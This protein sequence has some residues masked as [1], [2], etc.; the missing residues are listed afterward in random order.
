[1]HSFTLWMSSP[2][3]PSMYM[4]SP[5]ADERGTVKMFALAE[6][7]A[8]ED[9][10]ENKCSRTNVPV[11][12]CD[13]TPVLPRLAAIPTPVDLFRVVEGRRAEEVMRN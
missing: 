13:V 9:N 2:A 10:D 6:G 3:V 11:D 8:F 1:M 4:V 7:K 12:S 5:P